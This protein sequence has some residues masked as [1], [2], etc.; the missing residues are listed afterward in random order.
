MT[1]MTQ[2]MLGVMV[3]M[4]CQHAASMDI[5]VTGTTIYMSGTLVGGECDNDSSLDVS[6]VNF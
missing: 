5:T 3:V 1:R 2:K 4:F 6:S